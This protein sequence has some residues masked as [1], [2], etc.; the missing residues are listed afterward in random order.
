MMAQEFMAVGGAAKKGAASKDRKSSNKS[1]K[2]KTKS[3]K[4]T[5]THAKKRRPHR[6]GA[7]DDFSDILKLMEDTEN[8]YD[9]HYQA[10]LAKSVGVNTIKAMT[11]AGLQAIFGEQGTPTVVTANST[12]AGANAKITSAQV[13]KTIAAGNPSPY[14]STTINDTQITIT[15]IYIDD[16]KN[17]E[18]PNPENMVT[19]NMQAAFPGSVSEKFAPE[20]VL[21]YQQYVVMQVCHALSQCVKAYYSNY[22]SGEWASDGKVKVQQEIQNKLS[23]E[24]NEMFV[25][26]QKHLAD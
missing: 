16:N 18:G 20:V 24:L 5:P 12:N 10:S 6:G 8:K 21:M 4:V 7:D 22:G 23:T 17:A 3:N 26:V 13:L 19:F 1:S 14:D 9:P 15:P 2:S 25:A 11:V